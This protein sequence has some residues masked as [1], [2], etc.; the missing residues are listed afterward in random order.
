ME[1]E[2][3]FDILRD[4]WPSGQEAPHC[5]I[6]LSLAEAY[7]GVQR[8]IEQDGRLQTLT[9][10]AGV[11]TGARTYLPCSSLSSTHPIDFCTIV[12]H[13]QPPFKRCGDNLHLE[14][15]IDA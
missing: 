13:D 10:G 14:F 7:R 12:V 15:S 6:E 8:T 4:Y 5:V 11:H 1:Y 3:V 2:Q 9:I